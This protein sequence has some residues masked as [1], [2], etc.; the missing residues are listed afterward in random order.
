MSV[1]VVRDRINRM[2]EY[3]E[4]LKSNGTIVFTDLN[5]TIYH[6]KGLD[7]YVSRSMLAEY[8]NSPYDYEQYFIKKTA[9]KKVTKAMTNG[10]LVHAAVL[11]P[12]A[13]K[14][15]YSIC[16]TELLA[17]NGAMSTKAAKEY[18]AE[19]EALGK[20]VIKESELPG[21]HAAADA[22]KR[23]VP[24]LSKA[25]KSKSYRVENTIFWD[26]GLSD[27]KLKLRSDILINQPDKVM[28]IDI[29]YTGNFTDYKARK[30]I[31]DSGLV[32]Q[33]AHYSYGV[34]TLM[35]KPVDFYFLFIKSDGIAK[36]RLVKIK[37][38]VRKEARDVYFKHLSALKNSIMNNSFIDPWDSSVLTVEPR[39][40]SYSDSENDY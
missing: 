32:F 27:L 2:S 25:S 16:P 4:N 15:N 9:E 37:D 24:E 7:G 33:D 14:E 12:W 36:A 22:V 29:K 28:V 40:Y 34:E 31:E 30:F 6:N 1:T 35:G 3:L 18:K 38:H 21:I 8:I 10:S 11:Q 26:C 19:H 39:S 17:S 23:F 5:E 20:I 13:L